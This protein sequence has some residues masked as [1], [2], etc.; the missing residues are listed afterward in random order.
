MRA[1]KKLSEDEIDRQLIEDA[2]NPDAWE[3][4]ITVTPIHAQS[5][6]SYRKEIAIATS[7]KPGG[8]KKRKMR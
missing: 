6:S 7:S 3:P 5:R 1:Q 2:A 4:P 8:P